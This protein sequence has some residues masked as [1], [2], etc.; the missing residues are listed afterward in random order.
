MK[1]KLVFFLEKTLRWFCKKCEYAFVTCSTIFS[2][3][4]SK[5]QKSTQTACLKS[6]KGLACRL[7]SVCVTPWKEGNAQ[8]PLKLRLISSMD[9]MNYMSTFF[10]TCV[11]RAFLLQKNKLE[12]ESRVTWKVEFTHTVPLK[13]NWVKVIKYEAELDENKFWEAETYKTDIVK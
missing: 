1:P 5:L 6:L 2:Y 3:K 11:T 13:S 7:Q 9:Y 12:F 8:C 10:S 4:Q